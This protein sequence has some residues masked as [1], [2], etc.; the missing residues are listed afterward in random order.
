MIR[1]IVIGVFLVFLVASAQT[2]VKPA[3]DVASV[4]PQLNF[5][6]G[7]HHPGF[8]NGRFTATAPLIQ[9]IAF[10]YH[11]P[12]NPSK[13]LSGGP[14]WIRG[15]EGFYDVKAKGSVPND[16]SSSARDEWGRLMLQ[17]LLAERFKLA[18]HRETR[19]MQVYVLVADKSGLKLQNSTV[20]ERDCPQLKADGQMCHQVWGSRERGLHARAATISDLA[21]YAENWTDRP[22]LDRTGVGGFFSIEVQP[23]LPM[24]LSAIATD[25]PDLPSFFQAFQK[26][27]LKVTA[28]KAMIEAYVIDRVEKPTDN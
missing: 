3:F 27:G 28:Q 20:D 6:G 9:L 18:I 1:P 4:R 16:L 10:A 19:E 23:F 24:E 2:P 11:V 12:L 17:D 7:Y 26:L 8:V 5:P 22:L 13:R 15:S 25:R 21:R 14:D